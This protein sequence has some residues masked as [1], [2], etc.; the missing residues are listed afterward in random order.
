[1]EKKSNKVLWFLLVVVIPLLFAASLSVIIF[2]LMGVNLIEKGKNYAANVPVVSNWVE[3]EKDAGESNEELLISMESQ[4]KTLQKQ[5]EDAEKAVLEKDDEIKEHQS[6]I[7][8]LKD[9]LQ[10]KEED[11]TQKNE[12][13]AKISDIYTMMAPGNAAKIFESME[14]SEAARIIAS[15]DS[16]TQANV[17]AEMNPEKAAE[18]TKLL[19]N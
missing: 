15:L 7:A 19:T 5:I 6:D 16:D 14:Q 11:Q 12:S 3:I 9:Q 10:K 2:S 1:M 4:I 8:L 17:L 18:L 13:M